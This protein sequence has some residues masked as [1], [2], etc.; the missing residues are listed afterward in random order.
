MSY[1]FMNKY[2]FLVTNTAVGEG[3]LN[4]SLLPIIFHVN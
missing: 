2:L 4:Q 3:L 1:L